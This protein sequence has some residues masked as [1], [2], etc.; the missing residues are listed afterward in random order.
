MKDIPVFTSEYG[1]ASLILRE[2]PHRGE[3]YV[4]IQSSLEP[5][6]LAEE[7]AAFCRACGAE[8]VFAT[9]HGDLENYPFHTAIVTMSAIREGLPETDVS[10]WPVLPENGEQWLSIYRKKM[11]NVPNAASMTRGDLKEMLANGDAYFVHRNGQ[12][13]GI[14]RA[15][16][17]TIHAVASVQPGAGR[18]VVLALAAVLTGQRITLEVA[19]TNERAIRLYENLGFIVTGERSRWYQIF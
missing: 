19:S 10:L 15:S 17:E 12:L 1:V 2:I 9:G 8:R 3:A 4:R 16:G 14:G 11:A 18:D 7:C 13:L 6:L 5:K